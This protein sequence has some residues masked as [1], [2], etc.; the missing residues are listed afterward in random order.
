MDIYMFKK[1]RLFC[2]LVIKRK[3]CRKKAE[4]ILTSDIYISFV[5]IYMF[6]IMYR[7]MPIIDSHG[8]EL[9]YC[10]FKKMVL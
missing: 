2:R 7:Q 4:K 6:Y 8:C 3:K 5:K 1:E 9:R 10:Q